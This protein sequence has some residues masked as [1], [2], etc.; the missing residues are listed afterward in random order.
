METRSDLLWRKSLELRE[1]EFSHPKKARQ[2]LDELVG[3]IGQYKGAPNVWHTMAMVAGRVR[4]YDARHKLVDAG[5]N[6][7]PDNVD[8]LCEQLQSRYNPN[9]GYDPEGARE[10]WSTLITLQKNNPRKV[11]S[12]WRF[13]VYG[14]IFHARELNQPNEA[15]RL[16]DDG[17]LHVQR[18][19]LMDIFRTYRRV[20]IDGAPVDEL[21]SLDDVKAYQE[22]TFQFLE[23]KYQM[24]IEMGVEAAYV[25][26]LDLAKLYQEQAE[27]PMQSV[28]DLS[29]LEKAFRALD[30]AEKLYTGNLNHPVWEIYETRIHGYMATQDYESALH[31]LNSLP[32]RI[33][34][35]Q[36]LATLERLAKAKVSLDSANV[37]IGSDESR[38][39]ESIESS[40]S[41]LFADDGSLFYE[42]MKS[43]P[44]LV[45][46]VLRAFQKLSSDTR[47]DND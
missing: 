3:E 19:G 43:N 10:T 46:P 24:G 6:Q 26:A 45:N 20:L 2:M 14:A 35:E 38:I 15:L 9:S 47:E 27:R 5:L 16:L 29:Y 12:H 32:R 40:V 18:D 42:L 41:T 25:L 4:N 17:L 28:D 23:E 37:T 13:W 30:S 36:S 39:E 11:N 22:K 21:K 33:K 8:L 31:L 44:A 7:W 1:L 34:S